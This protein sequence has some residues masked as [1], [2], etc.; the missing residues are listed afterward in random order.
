LRCIHNTGICEKYNEEFIEFFNNEYRDK[1]QQQGGYFMVKEKSLEKMVLTA[2]FCAI[3]IAMTFIPQ[4]GYIVYGGLSITTLHVVV[5]LGAVMLGP[6]RGTILGLVW[7][8][9]C[10]IFAAMNGT[11]DAAIFLDPRISVIPRILVGHL[12]AWYYQGLKSLIG[13]FYHGG[14]TVEVISATVTGILGTLTNTVL[15]LT[16]ISL[17][18]GS[19][20]LKLGMVL[21][22]IIQTAIALNGIIELVLATILVPALSVPLFHMLRKKKAL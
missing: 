6:V 3:I 9:T 15:V 1:E 13:K 5:I 21:S 22:V 18:G 14:K 19:G 16:A 20:V 10:L 11:A 12:S 8:V 2:M 17:F 4:V 7:G